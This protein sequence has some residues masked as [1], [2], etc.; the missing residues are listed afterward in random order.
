MGLS[1]GIQYAD[2]GWKDPS[3]TWFEI[4]QTGMCSYVVLGLTMGLWLLLELVLLR[5][6]TQTPKRGKNWEFDV[7]NSTFVQKGFLILKYAKI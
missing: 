4:A 7:S 2:E 5:Q 6:C 3:Y 1:I